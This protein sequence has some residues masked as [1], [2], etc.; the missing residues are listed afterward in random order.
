MNGL[1][2]L[3]YNIHNSYL[4]DN[5][6]DNIWTVAGPEFGPEQVKSMLVVRSLYGLKFSGALFRALLAEQ[7]HDLC[8]R[9]S[10]YD[11]DVWMR[12]A[13]KP[14]GLIYYE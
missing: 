4:T 13:V 14:G 3:A 1:K 7:L 6:Q 5:C 9:P 12:Q 11:P 2:V 8:Y 10:I